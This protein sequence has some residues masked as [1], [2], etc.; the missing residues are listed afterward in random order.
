MVVSMPYTSRK[1]LPVQLELTRVTL[2]FIRSNEN[3]E[4][5]IHGR[6]RPVKRAIR[7]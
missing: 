2:P 6:R 4:I 5:S 3:P 7:R 1:R